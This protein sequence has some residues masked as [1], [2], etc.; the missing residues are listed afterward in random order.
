MNGRG[1][2]TLVTIGLVGYASGAR[3]LGILPMGA[4]SH[5]IIGAA[6]M[7]ALAAAGHEVTVVSPY[8]LKSPPKNYRDIELTGMLEAM[9]D[10]EQNLFNYKGSG[11]G[12]FFIMMYVLYGKLPEVVGK[13]VL[14]HPNVVTLLNSNEKFDLVIVE[15]FLTES[16]YGFAQ[17]FDAPLVTY[18]TF[19]NSMW[20]ND[21]VGTPAPPSHVAHFLLS[22]ADRMT[23]WER[24]VNTAVTILDRVVFEWYYLPKQKRFY[25]AGF[26]DARISFE[27]QMR[28]VSLVFLNQHFSVSSPRPYTPNMVEVGGIQVEKPKALPKVRSLI[29]G[30]TD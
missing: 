4:K 28:N 6:Y 19:G 27:D 3:I 16:L 29:R 22:Y 15:S 26:P 18:S 2:F 20:T 1:I 10:Q 12:S 9:D 11:I 25:E 13:L 21:L 14:Q 30:R 5:N 17:H 24:L 8:T 7:K 23:F